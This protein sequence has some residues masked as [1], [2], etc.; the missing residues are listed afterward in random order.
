MLPPRD[1][2]NEGVQE[3]LRAGAVYL[4]VRSEMEFRCGHV[5]GARNVPLTAQTSPEDFLH[6]VREL[7]LRGPLIV[8]C[9]SGQ[10]SRRA[11]HLLSTAGW[12]GLLHHAAGFEGTR[13]A[14]GRLTP[15]WSTAGHPVESSAD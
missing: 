9:Q 10:R 15:G 8:G 3:A 2:D 6:K 14:F 12:T 11:V 1:I 7:A 13:D 4:D 5:P